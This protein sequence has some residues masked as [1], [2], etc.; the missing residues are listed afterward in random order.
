M[1]TTPPP[2]IALGPN[3]RVVI[4]ADA[5]GAVG[6]A[7]ALLLGHRGLAVL[8]CGPAGP[9]LSN[10]ARETAAGGHIEIL[11]ATTATAADCD[12][13]FARAIALFGRVDALVTL[14]NTLHFEPVELISEETADAQMALNFGGPFRL[15]RSATRR[16]RQQRSG[17]VLC[18]THVAGRVALPMSALTSASQHA[19]VALCEA[20]RIEMRGFGVDVSIIETGVVKSGDD[21]DDPNVIERALGRMPPDFPY[22][23]IARS[24][25][26]FGQTLLNTAATPHDV[27]TTVLKALTAER[28][29]RRYRVGPRTN[30]RRL[31]RRLNRKDKPAK[32]RR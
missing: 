24:I 4:V 23:D 2:I 21:P 13:I 1:V 10:L 12:A 17:R 25:A 5:T 28:A 27:A 14:A 31:S 32:K 11:A 16:F 26:A 29:K 7:T 19:L 22:L 3:Q 18:I 6:R 20:L 15:I 30:A 9:A 8:A